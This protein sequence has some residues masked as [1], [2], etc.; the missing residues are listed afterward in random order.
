M[1]T[2]TVHREVRAGDPIATA[3]SRAT[4]TRE[5]RALSLYCKYGHDIHQTGPETYLCPSQDG[6]RSYVV[7]YGGTE[8]ACT[9]PNH[10][11]RRHAC[12]HLMAVAIRHAKRQ[13]Q[14]RRNFVAAL[15][16][17]AESEEE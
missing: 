2:V 11:Y 5:E 1:D 12:V 14:R 16:T 10:T 8:E 15:V 13:T 4:A 17:V 7:C 3:G 6:E 9:C